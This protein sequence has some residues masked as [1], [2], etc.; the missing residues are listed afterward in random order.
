MTA[1]LKSVPLPLFQPPDAGLDV[2][3]WDQVPEPELPKC[4]ECDH[5]LRSAESIESGVGPCC[6]AKIG[7]AE[8]ARRKAARK[9]KKTA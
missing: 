1:A 3:A 9:P 6:A 2:P 8:V 5:V 7:R 4:Q